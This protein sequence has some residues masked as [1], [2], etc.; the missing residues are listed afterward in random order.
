MSIQAEE[1]KATTLVEL[2]IAKIRRDILTG[3]FAPGSKLRIEELRNCYEIGA[4]PL[5]EALSRLV[6]GGL[7]TAQGQRGFRVAPVSMDDIRDITDTRRLL[8]NALLAQSIAA[9]DAEWEDSVRRSYEELDRQHQALQETDGASW[10]AWEEANDRFH[11]TLVS[12]CTSK[13]QLQFRQVIYDQA[14]RYRRFV[15]LDREQEIGA[16]EE[17][18]QM[19]QAALARDIEKSCALADAHAERTFKMMA[20]RSSV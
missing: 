16:Q 20:T 11:E 19:L 18:Y 1:F 6:S 10:E 7:V 9:G 2:A 4:S 14:V 12:A 15:V 13:W 5:R 17:H 3:A 8:E